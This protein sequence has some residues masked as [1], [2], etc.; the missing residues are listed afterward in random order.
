LNN[1]FMVRQAEHLA[2]RVRGLAP[3]SRAQVQWLYRLALGRNAK[4][5]ELDRM[6]DFATAQGLENASRAMLNSNEFLF[7]D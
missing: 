7:V 1:P 3:D 2:S 5:S 4:D 6:V